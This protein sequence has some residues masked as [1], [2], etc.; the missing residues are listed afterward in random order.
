LTWSF[1]SGLTAKVAGEREIVGVPGRAEA[2]VVETEAVFIKR[3]G[4]K[5]F[6]TPAPMTRALAQLFCPPGSTTNNGSSIGGA[7]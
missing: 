4:A 7:R 1:I 6:I 5:F 3:Q 2:E